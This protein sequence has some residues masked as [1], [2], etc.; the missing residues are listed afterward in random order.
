MRGT[1]RKLEYHMSDEQA[2]KTSPTFSNDEAARA[3][4]TPRDWST[5]RVQLHR[6]RRRSK[7]TPIVLEIRGSEIAEL[8]EHGLLSVEQ[9]QDRA[10]VARAIGRLL[11]RAFRYLLGGWPPKG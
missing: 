4:P 6:S 7:L 11:D 9:R 3:A 1:D 2:Q 8:V 10:A 5:P